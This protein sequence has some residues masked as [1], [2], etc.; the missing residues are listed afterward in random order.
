RARGR[1]GMR[2]ES[3]GRAR[4]VPSRAARRW[5][6]R[7]LSVGRAS[8]TCAARPRAQAPERRLVSASPAS[9]VTG[10][11]W[12]AIE[13][14]LDEEGVAVTPPL[15]D[16]GACRTLRE[17]FDDEATVFRATI[18]MARHSYGRGVYRYFDYPLPPEVQAL[19][20]AFYP[21]LAAIANKW[22][23][24]LGGAANWPATLGE[25][26]QRCHAEGQTRPTPLLLRYGPDDYNRL[27]QDLYGPIHFPLQV[28][29]LLSEPGMELDGG[30]LVLVEQQPRVQS[31]PIV[32]SL[33]L[34]AA[35]IVP[36]LERP[37]VGKR[38][39]RRVAMR[40]G[41]SRIRRGSRMTL[42]LIF[43]DAH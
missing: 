10:I 37:C 31:R 19:R 43:H 12:P 24:R 6:D 30:E 41:V 27:H 20:E 21:P 13:R 1:V 22:V 25:L 15:L 36:V 38:G 34:G 35:A 9:A 42:G 2:R 26:T 5:R 16:R 39:Y 8:Q 32:V 18:D 4:A 14:E 40:H 23:E 17:R 11:D 7:R 29:V 33:S 28:I 3:R